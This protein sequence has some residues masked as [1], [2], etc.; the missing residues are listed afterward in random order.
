MLLPALPPSA[1]AALAGGESKIPALVPG[2]AA[3]SELFAR[4]FAQEDMKGH[5]QLNDAG[6]PLMI[7]LAKT[8]AKPK[9]MPKTRS[10]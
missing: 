9:P 8:G 4:V 7:D 2:N 10:T 1:E 3:K 6:V 5:P